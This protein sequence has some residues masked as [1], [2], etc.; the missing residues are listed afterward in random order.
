[1]IEYTRKI[2]GEVYCILSV[3]D[4]DFAQQLIGEN[5]KFTDSFNGILTEIDCGIGFLG[6]LARVHTSFMIAD[7]KKEFNFIACKKSDLKLPEEK[8]VNDGWYSY[9]DAD[10]PEV[11]ALIGKEV[12]FCNAPLSKIPL[13]QTLKMIGN[14]NAERRY[15]SNFGQ[16]S[17][18]RPI[19]Q[20]PLKPVDENCLF[21]PVLVYHAEEWVKMVFVGKG[22][23]W[24]YCLVK[25]ALDFGWK[26]DGANGFKPSDVKRCPDVKYGDESE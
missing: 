10:K 17:F 19:Q 13:I 7:V 20:K 2:D 22:G 14:E 5:V 6:K 9:F 4:Y 12:E 11:Q 8:P 21:K 26:S 3:T 18:I 16:F 25:E 23:C 15:F 24:M 1:M